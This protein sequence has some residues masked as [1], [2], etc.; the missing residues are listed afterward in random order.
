M[1]RV[2]GAAEASC[3]D[4][5][6]EITGDCPIIDPD[7]VEQTIRM[8][9]YHN[10]AYVSNVQIRSYPDGMDTQVFSLDALKRSASMT[11]A[12]L[13]LEHVSLHMRNHPEIFSHLHLIAPP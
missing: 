11:N 4:V 5:I 6:V 10:A 1:A 12:P 3:A 7:I 13:D 9:L 2:I 8:Y